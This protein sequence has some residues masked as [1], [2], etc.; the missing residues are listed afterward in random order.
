M[1]SVGNPRI[2]VTYIAI[3]V[4]AVAI[5][6]GISANNQA[7]ENRKVLDQAKEAQVQNCEASKQPGGIRFIV[8]N[9]IRRQM[10]A[11]QGIDYGKFADSL[12][13]TQDEI[14]KLINEQKAAQT[15]EIKDLL[16]IDC[17][18]LYQVNKVTSP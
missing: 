3:L 18:D 2:I 1:Q 15:Q 7:N 12:G 10:I 14:N 6:T 16:S 5:F 11:S 9:E 4:S 8:A 13:L 17:S